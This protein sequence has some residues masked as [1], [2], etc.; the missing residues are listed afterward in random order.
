MPVSQSP[1]GQPVSLHALLSDLD[2]YGIL[3]GGLEVLRQ[4]SYG[5]FHSVLWFNQLKTRTD[6]TLKWFI[7][8]CL[9]LIRLAKPPAMS[10]VE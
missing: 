10:G 4:G 8:N 1:K 3:M 7:Y 9:A 5:G 2:S 6:R